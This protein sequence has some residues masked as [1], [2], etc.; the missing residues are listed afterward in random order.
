V[1]VKKATT[2]THVLN[3]CAGT[4]C[5]FQRAVLSDLG[6]LEIGLEKRAHLSVT[7]TTAVENGE[8]QSKRQEVD[9]ERNDDKTDNTG[10]DVRTKSCL[11]ICQR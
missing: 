4:N 9:Q 1:R 8:V 11:K 3:C 10:D 7:R 2:I 5:N 6:T